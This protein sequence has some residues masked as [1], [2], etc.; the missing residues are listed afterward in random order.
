MISCARSHGR[1][2]GP[3]SLM[4]WRSHHTA[5]R[6]V[7]V[8]GA[9]SS[10]GLE[11]CVGAPSVRRLDEERSGG[12]PRGRM[13]HDR[14]TPGYCH[15]RKG[16]C[17]TKSTGSADRTYDHDSARVGRIAGSSRVLSWYRLRSCVYSTSNPLRADPNLRLS[18]SP[19]LSSKPTVRL[20][21]A[22]WSTP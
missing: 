6:R 20:V 18:P 14:C 19:T 2:I 16:R 10:G 4:N 21:L 3:L 13:R 9:R 15:E 22:S 12:G 11:R 7:R 5:A 8:V 1:D 17:S